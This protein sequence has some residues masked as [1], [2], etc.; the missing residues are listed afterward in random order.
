MITPLLFNEKVLI[1]FR[2][3]LILLHLIALGSMC[4]DNPCVDNGDC[5]TNYCECKQGYAAN[6]TKCVE[7]KICCF[8]VST[9]VKVTAHSN[10]R[11]SKS[12][13]E[14]ILGSVRL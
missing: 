12:S 14:V 10:N 3:S 9:G 6:G 7:G 8:C 11:N 2:S 4:E 13:R 1:S 5:S